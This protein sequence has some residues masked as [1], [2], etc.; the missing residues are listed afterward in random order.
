VVAAA[1]YR[2]GVQP[3]HDRLEMSFDF[4]KKEG[5]EHREIMGPLGAPAA[6][7]QR[8]ALWDAAEKADRRKDSLAAGLARRSAAEDGACRDR[9]EPSR[10]GERARRLV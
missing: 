8:N 3:R 10:R 4:R 1:A 6:L 2:A 7:L 5:I 9:R